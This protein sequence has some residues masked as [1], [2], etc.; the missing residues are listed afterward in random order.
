MEY[1]VENNK[2]IPPIKN[3]K[4]VRIICDI[5]NSNKIVCNL[6]HFGDKSGFDMFG[7]RRGV[8]IQSIKNSFDVCYLVFGFFVGWGW[9]GKFSY[10]GG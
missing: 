7:G 6:R 1:S 10:C 2:V 3:K 9:G 8:M 4:L 5:L